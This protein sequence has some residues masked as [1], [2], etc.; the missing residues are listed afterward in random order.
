MFVAITEI[1]EYGQPLYCVNPVKTSTNLGKAFI[2]NDYEDAQR[3]LK[4]SKEVYD[5]EAFIVKM[6]E[7]KTKEKSKDQNNKLVAI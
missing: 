2:W 7:P 3:T 5:L 4:E 6:S 1:S